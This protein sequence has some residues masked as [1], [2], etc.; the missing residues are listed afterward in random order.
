MLSFFVFVFLLLSQELKLL[1]NVLKSY[2]LNNFFISSVASW[3]LSIPFHLF[4]SFHSTSSSF[5]VSL[6]RS[7]CSLVSLIVLIFLPLLPEL[8]HI[9]PCF[10]FYALVTFCIFPFTFCMQSPFVAAPTLP[11]YDNIHLL[12][13]PSEIT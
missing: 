4:F 6:L 11:L 5:T 7:T 12:H 10:F 9:L 2:I 8:Y 1:Q 13:T 3:I